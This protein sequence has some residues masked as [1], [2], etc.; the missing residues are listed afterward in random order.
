M[1]KMAIVW[2]DLITPIRCPRSA[3]LRARRT[4]YDRRHRFKIIRPYDYRDA[5]TL[6][7]DFLEAGRRGLERQELNDEDAEGRDCRLRAIQ[8][9]HDGYR[10]RRVKA[11]RGEPKVWFTSIESF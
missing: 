3:A 11:P 2:S 9:P 6:L 1:P 8:E 10:A 5:A 4:A 7:A